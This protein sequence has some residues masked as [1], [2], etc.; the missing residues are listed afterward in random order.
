MN[1]RIYVDTWKY[2]PRQVGYLGT[3]ETFSLYEDTV[4]RTAPESSIILFTGKRRIAHAASHNVTPRQ[5]RKFDE[6]DQ[7]ASKSSLKTDD[8]TEKLFARLEELELEEKKLGKVFNEDGVKTDN[9]HE[10]RFQSRDKIDSMDQ[11][12]SLDDVRNRR[13]SRVRFDDGSV[14]P[15]E[16]LDSTLSNCIK[17]HHTTDIT[18]KSQVNLLTLRMLFHAWALF[19]NSVYFQSMYFIGILAKLSCHVRILVASIY[20][21]ILCFFWKL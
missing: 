6:F 2:Y 10:Q 16:E 18:S 8:T 3:G 17:F 1:S 4:I 9:K 7:A 20:I 21:F 12:F 15:S 5:L 19:G 14:S 11:E 13:N